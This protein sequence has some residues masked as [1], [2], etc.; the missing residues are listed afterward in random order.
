MANVKIKGFQPCRRLGA[1]SLTKMRRRVLTNNTT[2]IF[3]HDALKATTAGDYLVASATNT[4]VANVSGGVSYVDSTGK[5][6]NS[7]YLPA[8]TLYTSTT[9]DP[10]NA[11]Y[12]WVTEDPVNT[13]F[14]CSIDEAVVLADLFLNYKMVLGTG[15]TTTGL[16]GHELD[17]TT[18]ATTATFPWRVREFVTGGATSDPDAAD[19][20]VLASI[21]VSFEEPALTAALGT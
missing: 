10:D 17:A 4:A 5:R 16:S 18:P 9:V 7:K 11:S 20:T 13:L 8:T 12:V 3:L 14:R 15:S 1:G 6:V 19:A 2:A 21:N